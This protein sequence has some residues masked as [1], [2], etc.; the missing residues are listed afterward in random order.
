[1]DP[2]ILCNYRRQILEPALHGFVPVGKCRL[3]PIVSLEIGLRMLKQLPPRHEI[4]ASELPEIHTRFLALPRLEL[5]LGF[6]PPYT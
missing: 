5:G 6:R 3:N 2:L 1:M 4:L